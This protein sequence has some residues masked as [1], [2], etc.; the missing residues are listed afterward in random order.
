VRLV[1][2]DEKLVPPVK[3]RFWRNEPMV[4]V[5]QPERAAHLAN[6]V[7]VAPA[8]LRKLHHTF[9]MPQDSRTY[10]GV[11]GY[12][13][14]LKLGRCFDY[15]AQV[16]N[17]NEALT[18]VIADDG[19]SILPECLVAES[20]GQGKVSTFLLRP[21]FQQRLGFLYLENSLKATS[22]SAFLDCLG[23]GKNSKFLPTNRRHL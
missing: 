5:V 12:L 15:K 11:S 14:K 1:D 20:E 6:K 19:V 18:H 13:R 9:L 10:S 17:V 4:L 7:E 8:D 23:E 3:T 21:A 2:D 16:R 22:V